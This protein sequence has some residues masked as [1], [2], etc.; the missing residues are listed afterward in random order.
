MNFPKRDELLLRT[1]L[2]LPE[3]LYFLILVCYVTESLE[4]RVGLDDLFLE[5]TSLL[6][7]GLFGLLSGLLGGTDD[8]EVRNDL[9][10]SLT[11]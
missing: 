9:E 8:G 6:A 2:A 1:V 3:L 10:F 7:F 5:G 11:A 4:D